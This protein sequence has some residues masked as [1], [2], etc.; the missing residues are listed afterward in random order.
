MTA[1]LFLLLPALGALLAAVT[2][3]VRFRIPNALTLGL[4][5]LFLPAALLAGLEGKEML[6]HL[7]AGVAMF[8]LGGGLFLA[9]LWGGG[10]AK[11]FAALSLW[12][13]WSKLLLFVFAMTLAGGFLALALLI[14]R[15]ISWPEAIRRK[16]ALRRLLGA[17]AAVPYG[18]AMAAGM[19]WMLFHA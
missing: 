16:P 11:L 14:L 10:D 17:K 6:S 2:D 19:I 13:G 8:V 12:L 9:R 5:V 18:I 15:R 4:A 1:S 7:G 3:F